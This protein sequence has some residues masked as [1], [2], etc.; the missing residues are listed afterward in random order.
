MEKIDYPNRK[1]VS[2]LLLG[3]SYIGF[4]AK[5]FQTARIK[6]ALDVEIGNVAWNIKSTLEIPEDDPIDYLLRESMMEENVKNHDNIFML[7]AMIYDSQSVLLTKENIQNGTSETITFAVELMDIFIE[8]ELKPKIIPLFDDIK[9]Q[10]RLNRL[11]Y[12][13]PPEYFDSYQDLLL[14]II[15]RDYNRINRYTKALAI[16]RFGQL[17]NHVTAD[18]IAN[19]FNSDQLLFETAAA[20][21]YKINKDSYYEH[22]KRLKPAMKKQLDKT[23]LPPVFRYEGEEYHQK[24]LFI[25]KI[26]QLKKINMFQSIPG[27]LVTYMAEFM[28]EIKVKTGTTLI[29]EGSSEIIP[30]YIIIDGI[31]DIYEKGNKVAEREKEG[32]LGERN[33]IETA[34]YSFTA[35]TQTEC[36]LLSIKREEL[37]NLMSKYTQILDCWINIMNETVEEEKEMVDVLFE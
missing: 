27:E 13:Y 14:Q 32:V 34:Q 23:I 9:V 30:M 6:V 1:I 16:Y 35:I 19:L 11:D 15:N 5:E 31:V 21:M 25:E 7:L 36:K 18:L 22:T 33:I 3:L 20:V 8:D 24:L 12:Y 28:D 17:S 29:Q 37:L 2:E 10:E 26:I 4:T